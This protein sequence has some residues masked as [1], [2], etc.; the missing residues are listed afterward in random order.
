LK[1]DSRL[2]LDDILDA[3]EK[4]ENYVEGL[5]FEQ[6]SEDSKTVD[7]IVR[8]FEIIGE[9][10]K[11][12]PSETKDKYPQIPWKMMAGTRDKLIHEYFGVNMQVLWKAVKEDIPPLK[13][14]IK[15]LL[16]KIDKEYQPT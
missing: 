12:I 10:T 11:R 6:F 5:T 4:I 2:Y 9:A 8:N 3:V 1:R 13:R 7:A 14:S 15:Q 16:Q